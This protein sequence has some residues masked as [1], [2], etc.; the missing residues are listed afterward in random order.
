MLATD[1]P[2]SDRNLGR[3]ARRC[4]A[5]LA[6]TGAAMSNGSG[7]YV[8]A[9][10]TAESVRRTRERRSRAALMEELPNEA[11]SPLFQSAIEATEEAIYNSLFMATTVRG[12]RGV[13]APALPLAR[14]VEIAEADAGRAAR[15]ISGLG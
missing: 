5:G 13:T 7:D 1:A 10:S 14:V 15:E 4:L 8:V 12:Y 3:L 2:L 6:R 11:M 9:F